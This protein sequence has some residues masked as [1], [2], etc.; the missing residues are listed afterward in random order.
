MGAT[1]SMSSSVTLPA[2]MLPVALGQRRFGEERAD[3]R[4]HAGHRTLIGADLLLQSAQQPPADR[5]RENE[6]ETEL[7]AF[8]QVHL[9]VDAAE[10]AVG[11][12][13]VRPA[14]VEEHAADH[15]GRRQ[16][17][18]GGRPQIHRDHH[19]QPLIVVGDVLP[20]APLGQRQEQVAG[21]E[22]V[23]RYPLPR[24]RPSHAGGGFPVEGVAAASPGSSWATASRWGKP[25]TVSPAP[26]GA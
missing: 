14:A 2:T 20:R 9:G 19:P 17:A 23:G 8:D 11:I 24:R 4:E 5:Q 6:G 10:Q 16:K 13:E 12:G 18:I 26:A 7:I 21:Q 15:V 25:D 22:V 3:V 1:E